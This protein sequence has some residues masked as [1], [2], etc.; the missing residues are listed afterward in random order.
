[1]LEAIEELLEAIEELLEAI[2]ELLEEAELLTELLAVVAGSLHPT[3]A[4]EVTPITNIIDNKILFFIFI[5]SFKFFS[6]INMF[7]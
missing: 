7:V 4:I 1:M 3:K 6:R 5:N 2:E